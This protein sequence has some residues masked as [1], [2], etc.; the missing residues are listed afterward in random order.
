MKP[1]PVVNE[2]VLFAPLVSHRPH[3]SEP[4]KKGGFS[5]PP[6]SYRYIDAGGITS[7]THARSSRS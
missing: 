7:R 2:K 3:L 5:H 1:A 4:G 6:F